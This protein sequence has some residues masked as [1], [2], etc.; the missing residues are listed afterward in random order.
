MSPTARSLQHL[1]ALGYHAKIVE[2]WN[3]FAKIRQDLLQAVASERW[4]AIVSRRRCSTS[5]SSYPIALSFRRAKLQS[6]AAMNPKAV[7]KRDSGSGVPYMF[8]ER[9]DLTCE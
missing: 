6:P 3:P 9:E 1:K 2:K 7:S 8:A 5:S 4:R